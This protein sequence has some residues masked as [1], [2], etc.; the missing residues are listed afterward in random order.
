MESTKRTTQDILSQPDILADDLVR[1][2][3][4]VRTNPIDRK[5]VQGQLAA[6]EKKTKPTPADNLRAAILNWALSRTDR[7]MELT[8]AIKKPN[9][10]YIRA[11]ILMSRG[12]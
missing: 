10:M 11:T 3:R 2:R 5:T 4:N 7:V 1:L 9:A 8:S 12:D 6:E